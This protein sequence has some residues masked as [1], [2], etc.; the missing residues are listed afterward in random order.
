MIKNVFYLNFIFSFFL[1]IIKCDESVSNGRKEIYFD[2]DEKLKLSSFFD[3]STNINLDVGENDELS[4]YVPREVDEKKK[5]NK[6]DIDSKENSKSGNNIYNKDNTKNNEDVNYNVVLKDGRAK[7][8]IITDEKRRSST[9]DGKNKEQNNNKMNSDDVHDNN[10]NMNDINF[11]VEYNKMI[12]NYD[13]ILD[14]LILKSIN[15]NNYNYFNMLDEYSLQTKLNKEMYDSLNYLIRLMNNKNSRKYFISFSN[16]EKKKII[17]N[18]MNENI[19]I[20]HFIVSLFRWYNNF[21]LIETCFD[22]NNFIYYIDEN[23]I[24][25]YKYNYKLMLNLFSSENFLYYINL[26][27]FSLLEII[28]NYNKYSFII[29]NIKRDYPNNMYVCQSFY[30]FIYSYFLSY[31]HHFF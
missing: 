23:K 6:K 21:K 15:R 18:D 3:R 12:D 16:N 24:Y 8:G 5:K 17:K 7:E 22:K 28:D 27:K 25:S 26:S 20:R 29:N 1:L 19:Y 9:K 2:D 31:N 14:E 30:D 4:S 11:V 10:N 13:K